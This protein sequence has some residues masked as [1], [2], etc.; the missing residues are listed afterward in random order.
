MAARVGV[1]D[2]ERIEAVRVTIEAPRLSK[3]LTV[4][5]ILGNKKERKKKKKRKSKEKQRKEY[6][7]IKIIM[8]CLDILSIYLV[9]LSI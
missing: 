5:A 4:K 1:H 9:M 8:Y 6:S 2:V 7:K 3:L